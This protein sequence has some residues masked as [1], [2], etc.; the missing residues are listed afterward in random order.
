MVF[1]EGFPL[2]QILPKE[3]IMLPN[4]V[5]ALKCRAKY[6]AWGLTVDEN[7]GEFA[8]CPYPEGMGDSGYYLLH[9]DHQHQGI[10][11]S[12]DVGQCCF[13]VGYAKR[14]LLSCD[15]LPENYFELWE[16]Y[17]KYSSKLASKVNEKLHAEKDELGRS[18][19]TLKMNKKAHSVKDEFGRSVLGVK[20]G[21]RLSS[22]IHSKRDEFG[23]SIVAV[24]AAEKANAEKDRFGRSV[25]A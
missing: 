24:K 3:F 5:F 15:I 22:A 9:N 4:E 13:F 7:N 20:N 19:H 14:W 18:L 25:N 12:Q 8:H 1:S 2:S 6:E 11:Q 16:I 17:E 23:R 21:E 10:L